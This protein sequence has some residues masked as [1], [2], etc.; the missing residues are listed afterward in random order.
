LTIEKAKA[1]ANVVNKGIIIGA[2]TVPTVRRS[3][4][5]KATTEGG[6]RKSMEL[7]SNR[8]HW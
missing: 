5:R 6:I 8:R 7:L 2:D 1:I 3:V 4:M